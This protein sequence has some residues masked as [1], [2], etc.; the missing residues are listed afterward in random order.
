MLVQD[1]SRNN[2]F[3]PVSNI[4]CFTF[5]NRDLF[6]DCR[7]QWPCDGLITRPRSPPVCVKNDYEEKKRPGPS[8][9]CR[10]IGKKKK[11]MY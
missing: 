1:M 5:Y 9:G 2:F 10:A 7:S 3:F 8:K 4:I 11:K 6:T